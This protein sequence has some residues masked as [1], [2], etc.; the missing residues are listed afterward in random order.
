MKKTVQ[1]WSRQPLLERL[2]LCESL[3]RS[4]G[5]LTE[6]ESKSVHCQI[7]KLKEKLDAAK[8]REAKSDEATSFID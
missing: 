2:V 4:H 8:T 6:V 1:T 5:C 7:L 3:L